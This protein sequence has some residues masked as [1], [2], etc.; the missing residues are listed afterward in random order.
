MIGDEKKTFS[1]INIEEIHPIIV[2]GKKD[3]QPEREIILAEHH[4]VLFAI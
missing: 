1:S 3:R 4:H 2:E